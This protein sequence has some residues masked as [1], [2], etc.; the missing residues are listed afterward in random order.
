MPFM[1]MKQLLVAYKIKIDIK[2]SLNIGM[3]Y[4]IH[5]LKSQDIQ[6]SPTF[7]YCLDSDQI[8]NH[9]HMFK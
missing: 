8:V 6:E 7:L 4:I 3:K 5:F 2:F 1:Q 9:C